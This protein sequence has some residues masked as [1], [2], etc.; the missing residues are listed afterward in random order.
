[1]IRYPKYT[2]LLQT[3]L[4]MS[5]HDPDIANSVLKLMCEM[6]QNR[7]QRLQ[8]DIMVANGVLLFREVSKT[9]VVYGK[10]DLGMVCGKLDL[11]I[12]MVG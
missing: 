2:Q 3:I 12:V 8:F 9:L 10:L 4:T 7:S 1:M 11:D 6:T 5:Y